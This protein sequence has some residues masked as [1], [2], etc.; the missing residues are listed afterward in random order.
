MAKKSWYI[1]NSLALT[2]AIDKIKADFPCFVDRQLIE[3]D[4]SYVQ[5]EAREEDI[6]A[7]EDILAPLM[8]W[9]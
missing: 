8:Q 1:E 3:M 9:G 2:K 7:I 5:V 6:Q 4:M